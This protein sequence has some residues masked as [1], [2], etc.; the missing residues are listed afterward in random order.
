MATQPYLQVDQLLGESNYRHWKFIVTTFLRCKRCDEF[1]TTSIPPP[2]DP[3]DRAVWRD[4]KAMAMS[5]LVDSIHPSMLDR[6]EGAGWDIADRDP[7]HLWT[8]I[9][10]VLQKMPAGAVMDLTR[11]FGTIESGDFPTL[12]AFLARALTLK[13]HLCELAGGDTPIFTY[14]LLNGIRKQYPALYEKH[15]AMG[16]VDWTAVVLDICHK[17]NAQEFSNSSLAAVQGLGFEKRR[18]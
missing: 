15:A 14:F 17:A 18:V 9:P 1:L 11:E 2:D 16:A 3:V 5:T 13:R 12:H 4:K 6:L 8:A 10:Q 7:F